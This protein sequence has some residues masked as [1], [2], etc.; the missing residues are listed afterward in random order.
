MLI[1]LSQFYINNQTT[2]FISN[3]CLIVVRYISISQ[4]QPQTI[5]I[6]DLKSKKNIYFSIGQ[7]LDKASLTTRNT[8]KSNKV[9]IFSDVA[10]VSDDIFGIFTL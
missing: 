9:C 10:L 5:M 8:V 3:N 1:Q 4:H 7:I 2:I 6:A